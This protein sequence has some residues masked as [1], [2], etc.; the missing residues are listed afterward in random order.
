MATQPALGGLD[1]ALRLVGDRWTLL[2]VDAL[3][4]GPRRFGEL[5]EQ[6]PGLAPNI[7]SKRLKALEGD[8]LVTA[9]PYSQRPYR[10]AYSLTAT[11]AELAGA[12]RLLTEWGVTHRGAS[13]AGGAGG[14][15]RHQTCGSAL[16]ARWW[17]PTC[18][19]AVDDDEAPDLD[20]L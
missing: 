2:V 6:L 9:A 4:P 14:G 15:L 13:A 7:L 5:L 17:C 20:Y 1:E 16:E 19:R 3:L 8:G 10:L 18:A 11:G 12:L